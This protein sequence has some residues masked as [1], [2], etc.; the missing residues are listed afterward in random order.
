MVTT[1]SLRIHKSIPMDIMIHKK[2]KI[3]KKTNKLISIGVP[4]P[5]RLPGKRFT[6]P[7]DS[8]LKFPKPKGSI[9]C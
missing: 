8:K 4:A 7:R 1:L 3:S 5:S 9:R 6:S 2:K